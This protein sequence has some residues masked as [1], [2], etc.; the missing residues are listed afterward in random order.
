[1]GAYDVI[2]VGLGA[3]GSAAAYHCAKR[4]IRVLGLDANP[5]RHTLGSSHGAT[6]AIRETYFESPEYVPLCQRSYELW[7]ELEAESGSSLLKT[8]GAIYVGPS[9]HPMLQGVTSAAELHGLELDHLSSDEIASRFSGFALPED[10]QGIFE[11]NGGVLQAEACLQAHTRL[12]IDNGADIR[13]ELAVKSWTQNASG[14]V[15]VETAEG[16]FEADAA[17]LTLGPWACDALHDLALPITGRRIP[18]IHFEAIDPARYDP[19]KM[20]VYFW[21][22][23]EGVYA[24]FPHFPGEGV[25]VMRHD[26]GDVCTPETARRDVSEA[27][28]RE[29]AGFAD[30]YMPYANRRVRKSL[31]GLYTMTP[32]NHFIIDH[33]PG[34][35]NV[36]YATGFSGHGFKFAPAVGEVLAEMVID[37]ATRHPTE[38]LKAARFEASISR[39]A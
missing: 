14:N 4:G 10:W 31:V 29:V 20:S 38:F 32:D 17:I 15:V 34:F 33:H 5:P 8:N 26:T 3:M 2:V 37:G 21:A 27:D 30:K 35:R 13:F 36:A 16:T 6:R 23:P 24:G 12:A 25:K 18:I 28:I 9:G 22:T 7:R 19:D 39:S 1:M 11:P